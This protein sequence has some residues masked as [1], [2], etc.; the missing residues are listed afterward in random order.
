MNGLPVDAG[1]IEQA[2]RLLH[3]GKLVAFPTE[4]VYGLGADA[5][6]VRAVQAIFAAKGR[7][8][9][10]PVIVH[11]ADAGAA[12]AWANPWP[13]A[14]R[15]L[16][17]CFWPGALTLVVARSA[18]AHDALTGAQSSV[19]LRCPSHPWAQALLR[20]LCRDAGDPSRAIAAPSANR[21]GQLSPTRA[22]HVL[23]DL[24]VGP[25]EP[26]ELVLDG[27]PCPVGIESTIVDL[28][29]PLPRLLRPGSITREQIERT[30]GCPVGLAAAD[31]ASA[32]RAPGR[33]ARHYAPRTPL[34]L[35]DRE[36]LAA[37]VREL[38]ATRV[39]V[40]AA[41]PLPPVIEHEWIAPATP[42]RYAHHL[43]EFLHQMD[44]SGAERLLVERPP[45]Q[46]AWAA[47]HDRLE[48][49]AAALSGKFDDAD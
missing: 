32:P 47:V 21:F 16:A 1:A 29:S 33:I 27:G 8:A 44:A 26:V 46:P 41:E 4:T 11:V 18:R 12:A 34:E 22:E 28:T 15:Q 13:A 17:D 31:D 5:D 49:A 35:V 7:P 2:A 48:R 14:A 42:D 38:G 43:Y 30:L 23:A 6:N 9:D 24:R 20:A 45:A 10:H 19:G 3:D 40:L 25:D 37:R 36:Q 39:A